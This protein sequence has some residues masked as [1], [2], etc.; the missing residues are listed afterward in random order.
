MGISLLGSSSSFDSNSKNVCSR[1]QEQLVLGS[2][3]FYPY[4]NIKE[5][6]GR[7]HNLEEVNKKQP[8]ANNYSIIKTFEINNHCVLEIQYKNCTNYEGRKILVFRNI[9]LIELLKRNNNLIDPHFSDNINYVSPV[10]R[11][12]PTPEGL[13]MALQFA[14]NI[15]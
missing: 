7:L 14:R 11:F 6:K 8:R 9:D 2:A 10:A 13:D 12:E 3:E 5:I 1:D 4:Q 15:L